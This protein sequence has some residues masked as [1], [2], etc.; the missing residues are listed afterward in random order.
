MLRA[1]TDAGLP[2]AIRDEPARPIPHSAMVA[3]FARSGHVLGARTLGLEV[4]RQM[5]YQ[6]YGLWAD[7]CA[8]APTLGEGLRR[9]LATSW[10][11]FTGHTPQVVREDRWVV[12]RY[13]YPS[14]Y[15][16]NR[17]HADHLLVPMLDFAR[18]YLGPDWQPD[19]VQVNYARD[20]DAAQLETALG[21]PI[22]FGRE[23]GVGIALRPEDLASPR[24]LELS[25]PQDLFPLRSVM[26]D[27]VLGTAP[28]PARSLSAVVALRLLDGRSDIQGAARLSGLSVQSLQRQLRQQNYT[29]RAVLDAARRARAVDLLL[30]TRR[31]LL[32]I[33]L[34]L[35]YEDHAN[36]T[37]AFKRWMGFSPSEFR[38]ASRNGHTLA[39]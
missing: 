6:G 13:P 9:G 29:Y 15:P 36:F 1:F 4:G 35:G 39:L 20:A 11:H 2:M 37:R 30:N 10:M 12:W 21:A 3:L 16:D 28:E 26:T 19:W 18:L 14:I 25:L 8:A 23:E 33:A 5:R 32:D 31:P 17:Q 22:R 7:Y 27:V 34:C 38:R 24:R